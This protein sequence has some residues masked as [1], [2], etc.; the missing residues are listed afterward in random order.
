MLVLALVLSLACTLSHTGGLS[1]LSRQQMLP[2]ELSAGG[3]GGREV[4]QSPLTL[5]NK[6]KQPR[7][8]M[9]QYTSGNRGPFPLGWAGTKRGQRETQTQRVH[10]YSIWFLFLA[11]RGLRTALL[12]KEGPKLLLNLYSS[13]LPKERLPLFGGRLQ[14]LLE[15]PAQDARLLPSST[16]SLPF[17]PSGD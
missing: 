10:D 1:H 6:P 2:P 12:A 17:L 16:Q 5:E 9:T 7:R 3:T 8:L 4:H 13:R 14:P 15:F 11:K